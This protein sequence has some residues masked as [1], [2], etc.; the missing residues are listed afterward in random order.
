M[1]AWALESTSATVRAA[2]VALRKAE[3]DS[4]GS[5]EWSP[6][7]HNQRVARYR[8]TLDKALNQESKANEM[9]TTR[10]TPKEDT[11]NN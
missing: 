1:M 9:K 11:S 7:L 5:K 10:T 2:G 4:F 6:E 8:A 3:W